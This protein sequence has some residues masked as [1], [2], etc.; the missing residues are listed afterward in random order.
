MIITI[1]Q[2]HLSDV[3]KLLNFCLRWNF[4]IFNKIRFKCEDVLKMSLAENLI[5]REQRIV[6]ASTNVREQRRDSWSM[7]R[8]FTVERGNLILLL[9]CM[10]RDTRTKCPHRFNYTM[11]GTFGHMTQFIRWWQIIYSYVKCRQRIRI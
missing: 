10:Y 8:L 3:R 4:H 9:Y 6:R 2:S 11:L 5:T 7:S 1:E